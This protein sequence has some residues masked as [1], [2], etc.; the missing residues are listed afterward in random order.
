M[1]KIVKKWAAGFDRNGK[2]IVVSHGFLQTAKM[3]TMQPS[4]D[5]R[6]DQMSVILRGKRTFHRDYDTCLFDT[7]KEAL[8]TL[9]REQSDMVKTAL[10]KIRVGRE[11]MW[12]I[13]KFTCS[14]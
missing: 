6:G 3:L 4:F 8:E 10:E 13:N 2:L 7:P 5:S 9:F 1:N 12:A 11:R 14:P